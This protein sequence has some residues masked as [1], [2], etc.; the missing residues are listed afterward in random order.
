MA[1][2]ILTVHY[3]TPELTEALVRSV[4]KHTPDSIIYIFDNSDSRPFTAHFP[5]VRYIDNT[6]GQIVDFEKMLAEHPDRVGT[7]NNWG[8]AKHCRSIDKCLDLIPDGFILIDSDML[9]MKD[10]TPYWDTGYAYVGE[11]R[12]T[13]KH[14]VKIPRLWPFMCFLNAPLLR[15]HNVRYFNGNFMWK[16]TS[17]SPNQWYDTGAWF[18]EECNRKG[19]RGRELSRREYAVHFGGGSWKSKDSSQWI[20]DHKDLWQ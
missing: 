14:P 5:N 3:N 2:N 7:M 1:V 18:L 17:K 4:N 8:S 15:E 13:R 16:L 20:S 6:K 11:V 12:T 9:V 10:I 19:L